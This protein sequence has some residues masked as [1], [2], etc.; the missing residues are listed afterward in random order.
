MFYLCTARW[1]NETVINKAIYILSTNKTGLTQLL[2]M[3][4]CV[5]GC[6]VVFCISHPTSQAC[7]FPL[8]HQK[9]AVNIIT[10]F[11]LLYTGRYTLV[12]TKITHF[13]IFNRFHP[14]VIMSVPSHQSP[15]QLHKKKKICFASY[16][17]PASFT[18]Q[19]GQKVQ[20]MTIPPQPLNLLT[21]QAPIFFLSP[22]S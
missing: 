5:Y 8:V 12:L 20:W 16:R 2:H 18:K 21:I 10:L 15:L 4:M 17:Q 13:K 11:R 9:W 6:D 19:E 1:M 3:C 14:S 22:F 7:F